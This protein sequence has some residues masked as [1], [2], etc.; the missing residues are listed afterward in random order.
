MATAPETLCDLQF[1]GL[2]GAPGCT[3]LLQM[4]MRIGIFGQGRL[5]GL[6]AAALEEAGDLELAWAV[7]REARLEALEHVDVA[8]DVSHA[9]GV[10]A[11]LAWARARGT[12]L[13]IGTTGWDRELLTTVDG[14]IGVLVAPNFSL[15]MALL[16]RIS[17]ALGRY[18][19]R[20]PEPADLTVL[21]RHHRGKVDA[22]S[23]SALLL[24]E[25]LEA[26]SGG[27][28]VVQ[29]ASQ[30]VGA[31]VGLHEVRYETP[32]ETISVT[33]EA[34]TREV[35]AH[36]AVT[37]LRW[38]HGRTGLHTFDDLAAEVLDPLFVTP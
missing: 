37:A 35:F 24:A 14:S 9:D 19:A 7:G 25:A 26:G 36:G 27:A 38:V 10:A 11:H 32:S 2:S 6:V 15:S 8:L 4:G 5:G 30:R 28:G 13:V 18:A 29:V 3:I 34:H 20:S 16:R 12:D 17:L 22:P 1:R 23:G 21:D 33:H 31:I